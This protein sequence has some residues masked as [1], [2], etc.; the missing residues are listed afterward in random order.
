MYEI[1]LQNSCDLYFAIYDISFSPTAFDLL[2]QLKTK[3]KLTR[4]IRL[5]FR[6]KTPFRQD[7]KLQAMNTKHKNFL[8]LNKNKQINKI[9]CHQKF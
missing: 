4:K 8:K 5:F 2:P 6:Y 1:D 7:T 9:T 3:L